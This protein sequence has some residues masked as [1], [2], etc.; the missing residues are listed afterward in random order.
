MSMFTLEGNKLTIVIELDATPVESSSKKSLL[1][2]YMRFTPTGMK[3]QG[4]DLSVSVTA[5]LP[6]K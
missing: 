4:K 2:R 6:N 1:A 5:T 3:Y